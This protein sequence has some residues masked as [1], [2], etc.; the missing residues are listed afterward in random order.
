MKV[1]K[2]GKYTLMRHWFRWYWVHQILGGSI[3]EKNFAR[4]INFN[5]YKEIE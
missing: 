2:I 1:V 4:P 3:E 5:D